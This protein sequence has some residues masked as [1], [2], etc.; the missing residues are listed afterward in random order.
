MKVGDLVRCLFQPTSSRVQDG[1]CIPM[2]HTIKGELGFILKA[3]NNGCQKVLFPQF[4]YVHD[5]ANSALEIVNES[6]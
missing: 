2:E 4:G 6:R 1:V 5:I 3:R